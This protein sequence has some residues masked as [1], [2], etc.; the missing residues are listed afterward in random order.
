MWGN[1]SAS[2]SACCFAPLGKQLAHVA[3]VWHVTHAFEGPHSSPTSQ[4]V[5]HG[6]VPPHPFGYSPH[7][8]AGQAI[9]THGPVLDDDATELDDIDAPLDTVT[10]TE[11]ELSAAVVPPAPPTPGSTAPLHPSRPISTA[12]RFIESD[13]TTERSE[14]F[15]L[16]RA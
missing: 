8:P 5:T 13:D 10:G 7:A 9:G 16:R 11:L 15:P 3:G 1:G 6:L 14:T 12:V 2:Q 4:M